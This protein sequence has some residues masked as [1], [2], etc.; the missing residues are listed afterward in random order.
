MTTAHSEVQS[1]FGNVLVAID[2]SDASL[3]AIDAVAPSVKAANGSMM[4][5]FVRHRPVL[6]ESMEVD[7]TTAWDVV[8]DS[9]E[10]RE[11]D[12][13][14]DATNRLKTHDISA[15]FIVREGDPG[16]EILAV[17]NEHNASAVVLGSPI[18]GAIGAILLSSVSEYLV[19]H[20]RL[21]LLLIRPQQ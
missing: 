14:R 18:H 7:S 13:E 10:E 5:V 19:H 2:D 21:P 16:R 6:F 12:A 15:T 4:L 1:L 8:E 20:C 3:D 11:R 9:L 17:A